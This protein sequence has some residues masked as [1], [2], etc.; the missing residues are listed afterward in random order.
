METYLRLIVPLR[1]IIMA[2]NHLLLTSVKHA[3][4]SRQSRHSNF[5]SYLQVIMMD[6]SR[7]PTLEPSEAVALLNTVYSDLAVKAVFAIGGTVP[8][9]GQPPVMLRW[10]SREA[11]HGLSARLPITDVPDGPDG[12]EAF[13]RLLADCEPATFGQGKEEVHDETYRKAGKMTS[14]RFSSN[15]CPY[16]TG[17]MDSVTQ[18][19]VHDGSGL[20]AVLYSLNVSTISCRVVILHLLKLIK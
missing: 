18:A 4:N 11:Y 19:L 5:T 1:N 17:V 16:E 12:Q 10:D 13:S 14:A 2:I 3:Q 7:E 6:S 9:T 20:R 8:P 15:F